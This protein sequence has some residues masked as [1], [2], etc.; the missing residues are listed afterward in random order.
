MIRPCP[1]PERR[2]KRP[3]KGLKRSWM[4][5]AT[6]FDLAVAKKLAR[7]TRLRARGKTS[8]A[9]RPREWAYMAEVAKLPCVVREMAM[10]FASEPAHCAGRIEVNHIGGRYG[11]DTDRNTVPMCSK[12]HRE[13]TGVVG[14]GGRFAGWTPAQRRGW[15]VIAIAVTRAA[16]ERQ[17]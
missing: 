10:G 6:V 11:K 3:R 2:P 5:K 9:R 13:W 16:I 17:R 15:G 12:H 4:R 7:K 8:H 14:G 1:K